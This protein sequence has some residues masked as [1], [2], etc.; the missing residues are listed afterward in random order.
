MVFS[1]R[2]YSAN[3]GID[4]KQSISMTNPTL[5]TSMQRGISEQAE[6]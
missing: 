1:T 2:K 5:A 4:Y 3:T 6:A